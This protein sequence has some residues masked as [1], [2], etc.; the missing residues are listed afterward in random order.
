VQ[1][2]RDGLGIIQNADEINTL[3]QKVETTGGLMFVPAF[4]GWGTPHWDPHARG[5]LIGLTRDSNKSH[6]ALAAL[7]GIALSVSTL[8]EL[9]EDS[10]GHS[11][12][13]LAVD[14]GAAASNPLLKAQANITGLRV[15][16]PRNIESTAKGVAL[17]AG[18]QSGVLSDLSHLLTGKEEGAD[19][20][21]PKMDISSRTHLKSKWDEA[22]KR[23]LEWHV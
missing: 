6:I 13:E 16:R 18:L 23:S 15:R 7:E 5:L 12:G 17:L 19:F 4:T 11:L 21:T 22:V 3:A 9:A 14:G 1:W 10:L 8:V 2:L 20:F